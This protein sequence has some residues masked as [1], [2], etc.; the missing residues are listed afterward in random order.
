M[1]KIVPT[2]N[3]K[4]LIAYYCGVFSVC[5]LPAPFGLVLGILGLKAIK[6]DPTMPGKTHAWVGIILGSIFT[7]FYALMIVLVVANMIGSQD[8]MN[9][10]EAP[11]PG[12]SR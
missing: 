10:L 5:G 9:N 3:P 11:V 1:G 4:A 12:A 8:R 7:L 6:R 2:S